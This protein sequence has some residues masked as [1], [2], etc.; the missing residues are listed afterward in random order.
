MRGHWSWGE[1]RQ[2]VHHGYSFGMII[3]SNF[4]NPGAE[5]VFPERLP[6]SRAARSHDSA[7]AADC[8]PCSFELHVGEWPPPQAPLRHRTSSGPSYRV[9]TLPGLH[10]SISSTRR[11]VPAPSPA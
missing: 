3:F 2:E 5:K 1:S 9:P 7:P 8:L 6:G 4:H 10:T 11:R